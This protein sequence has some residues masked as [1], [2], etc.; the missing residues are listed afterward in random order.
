MALLAASSSSSAQ[1][2]PKKND[3][4]ISFRGED[5]RSNFTSHLYDAFC[6]KQIRT[7]IDYQ[8]VKGDEISPSLLQA[9][10]DSYVSVVVLSENYASSRWC[11]DE[12][13][14]ILH[15]KRV[16]GQ[17]V[18]PVFYKV[19]PSHV[20]KQTGLYKQAFERYE[21][22]LKV[23]HHK[24]QMW[25]QALNETANLA[26]YDSH[27]F[28][29][30]SELIQKIAKDILQKLNH[31]YPPAEIKG[32]IGIEDN[33]AEIELLLKDAKTK[34]IGIWGMGGIGKS[35]IAKTIF[36]KY[37]SHY[38]YSCFLENV[39]GRSNNELTKLRAEFFSCLLRDDFSLDT[40]TSFLASRLS[41]TKV[42]VVLDDISTVGQL[43]DL[44]G[45]PFCFGLGS[46]I[47]ITT[48]D[49]HVLSKGVDAI[50]EVKKLDFHQSL[51]LFSLNAFSTS[52][53]IMGYEE[54][55]KTAVFYAQG[56]PLALKVL[57]SYLRGKS[58]V[59]WK[60]SLK[61]LKKSPHKEIQNVLRLSYD[62]LDDKEKNILL[63]IACFL[64]GE[65]TEL[66][67]NLLDNFGFYGAI[68]IRTLHDKALINAGDGLR[69]EMHDLIQEMGLQIARE[70]STE[71][72]ERRRRLWDSEEIYDVLTSNMG[73]KK[74]EAIKLDVSQVKDLYLKTDVF[75][76]MPN[77]R[78]LRFYS[79]SWWSSSSHVHLPEGLNFLPNKMRYLEW[80]G[81][82][83]KSPRSTFCPEKLVKLYLPCSHLQ[84]L[85]NGVQDLVSLQE[86]DLSW[87]V[88]LQELPNLSKCLNLKVVQL[89]GC[90][91]LCSVHSSILSLH[92]LVELDLS[93]C[94]KL[95]SLKN[96][97]HL[98]SLQ[99][100]YVLGCSNLKEFSVSSDELRELDLIDTGIETL[101]SS[102]ARSS[103]LEHLGF[104]G[105]R[106]VKL[107]DQLSCLTSLTVLHLQNCETID[108]LKLH[109]F[110]DGMLSLKHVDLIKCRNIT[111]LPNNTK[112]LL[113]LEWLRV[114]NCRRL[115][116][117]PELPPSIDCLI[118]RGCKSLEIVSTCRPSSGRPI[119]FF[120][121]N[122]VQLNE[123]SFHNIMEAAAYSIP[124]YLLY[125]N[126]DDWRRYR[127]CVPGSRVPEWIKYW[128]AQSSVTVELSQI[129]GLADFFFCIVL[130][131]HSEIN[132]LAQGLMCTCHSEGFDVT[133]SLLGNVVLRDRKSDYVFIWNGDG[134]LTSKRIVDE[135]RRRNQQSFTNIKLCFEFSAGPRWS[136]ESMTGES[137]LMIKE[138][139]VWPVYVSECQKFV[140][141]MEIG[142]K[143]KRPHDV[144]EQQPPPHLKKKEFD[145]G[146]HP[147]T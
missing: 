107:P 20:R 104:R 83:L 65:L 133:Y 78:F 116:S 74:V 84:K 21:G 13:I 119:C 47:L 86:I 125:K 112:R 132:C 139:G 82:A 122:C 129:S 93:R 5:T 63:D 58:E 18:I 66:V 38:D 64:N 71:E 32:L 87:S 48:R 3:V 1:S 75:R 120:F 40:S 29:D 103:K 25:K 24:M 30:E 7:Y 19:D 144:E 69:V 28:R 124:Y 50:Y 44:V 8:L 61:K 138:C 4:F 55:T 113:G 100:I 118:A 72:P 90:R 145:E 35:T 81:F 114:W 57:G 34:T 128:A 126:K 111:E 68:G 73:S 17:I 147:S 9:I 26:G 79:S 117:L 11:L 130:D 77:M 142:R 56:I 101:R 46:K 31:K 127:I 22:D 14:H 115:R 41:H 27:T 43:E 37:S 60:S 2:V 39:R 42:F 131:V 12:L 110:F 105:S 59:E 89:R 15:C 33:C 6:R 95:R 53:P 123:Q 134:D 23:D 94:V 76:K 62:E 97:L 52:L 98:R 135:I 121:D 108:D 96:E 45:E 91:S 106:L 54:L 140:E 141:Q 92:S 80:H 88:Q 36:L 143:R 99:H 109:N 102:V 51:E 70:E 49:K 85:W 16:Q 137:K 67:I 10:E 146:T 136:H